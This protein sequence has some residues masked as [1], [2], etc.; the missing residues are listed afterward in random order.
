MC[1]NKSNSIKHAK[2]MHYL[3]AFKRAVTPVSGSSSKVEWPSAINNRRGNEKINKKQS[4]TCYNDNLINEIKTK[5]KT[6]P[7]VSPAD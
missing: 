6:T 2:A 7:G 4:C 3:Y 1:I 5:Y